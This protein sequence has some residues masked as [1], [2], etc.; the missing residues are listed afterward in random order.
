MKYDK[1]NHDAS[2][3]EVQMEEE[4]KKKKR[5]KKAPL[6]VASLDDTLTDSPHR[7]IRF[8]KRLHKCSTSSFFFLLLH[9]GSK[10][11]SAGRVRSTRTRFRFRFLGLRLIFSLTSPLGNVSVRVLVR[12]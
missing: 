2:I 5:R 12:C 10:S 3:F 9:D 8:V 6:Q 11:A 1:E 4:E 7:K